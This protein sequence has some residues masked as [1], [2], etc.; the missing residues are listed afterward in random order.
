MGVVRGRESGKK[1]RID[2][3]GA[4]SKCG[5]AMCCRCDSI[6]IRKLDL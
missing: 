5:D 6:S 4:D 1:G 2:G 3:E